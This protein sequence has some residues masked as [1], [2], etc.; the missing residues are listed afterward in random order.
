MMIPFTESPLDA[1]RGSGRGA[2]P[3]VKVD[4]PAPVPLT[5]EQYL[6]ELKKWEIKKQSQAVPSDKRD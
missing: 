6:D 4:P 2:K 3:R 1:Y 5:L